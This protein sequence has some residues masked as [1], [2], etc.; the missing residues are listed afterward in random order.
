MASHPDLKFDLDDRAAVDDSPS[1]R[2]GA[3]PSVGDLKA[4]VQQ[5][6]AEVMVLRRCVRDSIDL[7]KGMLECI[8][9]NESTT[10]VRPHHTPLASSTP[11][12]M[13]SSQPTTQRL[14]PPNACYEETPTVSKPYS[15]SLNSTVNALSS[16]LLQSRLEPP[17]F[18]ADGSLSP[19]EWLQ[20]VNNYRTS[21]DLTDAQMLLELPRFLSKEPRKWFSVLCTQL[22]SW[23][24]FCNFFNIVYLPSD[25]QERILRGILD[26]RQMPEE[27]LPTFVAHMLGEF[28]KLRTPP[29]Q[30]EQIDVIR[31]HALEKYRLALYGT[32]MPSTMDLLLRAHELHAVL[33][34][35]VGCLPQT[36][37]SRM[38]AT[39]VHCFKCSLPGFTTRTCPNCSTRGK[40]RSPQRERRSTTEEEIAT[41][42][43]NTP[44]SRTT[45]ARD[46]V[47]GHV[48]DVSS[49]LHWNTPFRGKVNLYGHAFDATLDTGASLSAVQST[50]VSNLPGG[51]TR[52]KSWSSPPVQ[53]ADGALCCPL[54]LIWL[55]LGFMGQRFYQRF[56]V[57]E[58]LSSPVVLGMDFLMRSSATLHVP[59][60]TV[61]LGDV[62]PPSEGVE[63]INLMETSNV[64]CLGTNS[65]L[66]SDK[67]NEAAI[68]MDQKCML[69]E[70]LESFG[71][72]FDGHL[73]HTSLVE[74]EIDIGNAKPVH[75][76]PYRTSP[77]KKE[78]IESQIKDM[79]REGIIEPAS[80][81]WAA[82]VVI[83]PKPSGEPRFCVD[84][85]A[86][87][88]LTVK[89]SYPLPR[90]DESLDF[91]ARG[92]F[93]STIDLARGYWQ[94]AMSEQ[95]KP[96]TAFISHCGLYQFRV[97]P[98]G[99][100][101]APATF[102]RLM[103]SVLAGLIYKSCAVYLDDIVVASPTFDQHIIDLK[104]VLT[105]LETAGLSVK[106][107]K[108]QFCRSEL[109]FLGYNVTA[110]GIR[111]CVEKVRA[112]TEFMPPT[113]VKQVRQFL[114]LTGY[115]RRFIHEYAR[116][117]EPLFALTR[118]DVPF[119]W[120]SEC[121]AAM[122]F[123]KAKLTSAPILVFPNF[124]LPFFVHTD[125]CDV[126]LGAALMQRDDR[127]RDV[128]VAYAS[129]T[130]H[131]AE[132]PYS[133]SEKECLAVIWA[134]EHFRSYI[135]GL[136]VTIFSDH[137]SLRWLMSRPNLSGRLA[138]WS[139]RLQDFDF[140]INHKPGACNQVPDA[141]SRNP[142]LSC[143]TQMDILPDYAVIGGLDLRTL[144]P[145]VFSDREHLRQMQLNDHDTGKLLRMLEGQE[146]HMEGELSQFE[147][148]DG[149]LYFVDSKASCNLHPMKRLRLYAPTAMKRSLL[150]Y[151]HD[152]PLAGHLGMS[153]TLA[154]LK[155][156]FYWPGLS[157]D[158]KQYVASCP[159][160]QFTKPSQK[161]P[162]GLMIP[163]RPQRPWEYTGVDFVGPLPRTPGGNAYILVFVDYF[164]K[165]VEISAVREATARVAASK[166]LCDV[167][168]RHGAPTYL[169][170][171][172][173]SPFVS[174]LFDHVLTTLGSEHRLTTAYH[175]QTN[176]TERV[177][178]SLKTA[179]RAY[180]GNKH[181]AWDRYLPQIC[182]ALRT[183]THESTGHSP[184]MLLYGRELN[185]PLDIITQ[186]N[187]DGMDEPGI[188]YPESLES[189][190]REA[191]DH[192]RAV[193]EDSHAKRK[194]YYDQRRRSVSYSVNDL[195]RVK[196]H[197]RSDALA[198]FT[199]KLA[200]LYSG[201][202]RVT[203]KLSDV[204]YRLV[205]ADSGMDAGVFHVVN[206]LPFRTWDSP[207]AVAADVSD[208]VLID[209]SLFT[210]MDE[211]EVSVPDLQCE[212]NC[213][214]PLGSDDLVLT[215]HVDDVDCLSSQQPDSV[216]QTVELPVGGDNPNSPPYT[217][218]P[219]RVPRIT[220]DWSSNRWTNVYHTN[221]MNL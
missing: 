206:L 112:V 99:L 136:H 58:N 6:Q 117:A 104:D 54:G 34:P 20:S 118:T 87:N 13:T 67:V 214:Q 36:Q 203:Q 46:Q 38:P 109:T 90:I 177:N 172:R 164:S 195:V 15:I 44:R 76:A 157:S 167:F 123:L 156:R 176:A 35:S 187:C 70:L 10:P 113:C 30:Q 60:R 204:N 45:S 210:E 43:V 190:I 27:P 51:L 146:E 72:L 74:H 126:G 5:L 168:A 56:A 94:V 21:L 16:L 105:R 217:L 159:T 139:L 150:E 75:L 18:A 82:P 125:A 81:P 84:Y 23:A 25:S 71:V 148:Q 12:G 97:L 33:G 171:D 149:L 111:P 102:Q 80:G 130:L 213:S 57:F 209:R 143:E 83:V 107:A 216:E 98:F 183:A 145:V 40:R 135:E 73:G 162:A 121:Q 114:G 116:H 53:L 153:K 32:P 106:L 140:D 128:V 89:D 79:L 119:V 215:D 50:V 208:D 205:D 103:N 66:L 166:L 163:I 220:S 218:R 47:L 59:S 31:K 28:R 131:K 189:S 151:Y 100:C 219:R 141:L 138:R 180:V 14:V 78:L 196:T 110:E 147:I 115:Y 207:E 29:P 8:E 188:P 194:K 108:C 185:T 92:S 181:T 3:Q 52:M 7:Q 134:L 41:S 69:T 124:S 22:T 2:E 160:C 202:Y 91:L 155:L 132:R 191:Q 197:P 39:D 221:R 77:A 142:V 212:V 9:W 211:N 179:I 144:P 186:P 175:P 201:P 62:L 96:M 86:L 64:S 182:F 101:N 137:N 61:A 68:D 165:W 154:R 158:A 192:A 85:R 170:S 93:I 127:G 184:S 63:S 49:T 48:E 24:Q 17:V 193:L 88:K 55:S 19:E 4:Q 95:S 200:P 122:D 161:K 26:R 199:A 120:S 133:T 1:Q 178:R 65:S 129:R 11:Y 37:P 198:N 42:D 152:H 173:G 169:I 174:E